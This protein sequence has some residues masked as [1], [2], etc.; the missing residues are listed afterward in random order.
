MS[1][2]VALPSQLARSINRQTLSVR[3]RLIAL[4][5]DEFAHFASTTMRWTRAYCTRDFRAKDMRAKKLFA[6]LSRPLNPF[7]NPLK[8]DQLRVN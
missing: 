4:S 8:H 5:V 1:F 3:N 6:S 7:S 2:R